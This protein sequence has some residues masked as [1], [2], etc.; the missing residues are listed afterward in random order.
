MRPHE[1]VEGF[2]LSSQERLENPNITKFMT[3]FGLAVLV[4]E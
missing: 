1:E 4:S 3:S 2:G